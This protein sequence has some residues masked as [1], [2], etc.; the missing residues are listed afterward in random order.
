[1]L[2]VADEHRVA[3]ILH[4][5]EEGLSPSETADIFRKQAAVIHEY[6][7]S[8]QNRITFDKTAAWPWEWVDPKSLAYLGALALI[9]PPVTAYGL[10]SV[11]GRTAA[12]IATPRNEVDVP[13]VQKADEILHMQRETANILARVEARKKEEA[14]KKNNK[15]VR[16][17]F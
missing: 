17:L 7:D 1:M 15:S 4:C 8:L 3:M 11:G 10:G 2:K 12:E 6:C 9:A 14:A 5:I 16:S 13:V